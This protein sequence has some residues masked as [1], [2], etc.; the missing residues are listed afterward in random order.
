[1]TESSSIL[2]AGEKGARVVRLDLLNQAIEYIST[3]RDQIVCTNY[4]RIKRGRIS[5]AVAVV[6]N[7]V[8]EGKIE[9]FLKGNL[10]KVAFIVLM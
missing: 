2:D 4:N 8:P 9:V 7:G 10:S 6:L 5:L 3:Y 1:M